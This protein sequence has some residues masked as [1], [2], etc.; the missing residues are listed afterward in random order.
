MD[1]EYGQPLYKEVVLIGF[2]GRVTADYL[3]VH[4]VIED[5]GKDLLRIPRRLLQGE[6]KEYGLTPW[7][8]YGDL[9]FHHLPH[10]SAHSA[11]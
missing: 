10:T 9:P 2:I 8:A 6:N 1:P 4:L 7:N 11:S 5:N 3:Y